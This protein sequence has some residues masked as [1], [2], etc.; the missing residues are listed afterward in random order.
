MS[1]SANVSSSINTLQQ[2]SQNEM[3]WCS[4]VLLMENFHGDLRQIVYLAAGISFLHL[5]RL[6]SRYIIGDHKTQLLTAV[7]MVKD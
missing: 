6:L 2:R 7:A 3:I 5:I 1:C 4:Y